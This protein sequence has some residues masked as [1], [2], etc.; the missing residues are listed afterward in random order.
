[1]ALCRTHSSNTGT[2]HVLLP[3]CVRVRGVNPSLD[4]LLP[5]AHTQAHAKAI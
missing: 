1:M 3:A 2:A 5:V 4:T